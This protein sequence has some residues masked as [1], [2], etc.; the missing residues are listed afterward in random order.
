MNYRGHYQVHQIQFL[1]SVI[2]SFIFQKPIEIFSLTILKRMNCCSTGDR[3]NNVCLVLDGNTENEICTNSN[4]GFDNQT[5]DWITWHIKA[6]GKL[7][8]RLTN[9]N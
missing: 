7:I 9:L 3:Y 2:L 1:F 6:R 4:S 5:S 8:Q